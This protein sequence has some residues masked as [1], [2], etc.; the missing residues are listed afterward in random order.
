[1]TQLKMRG[2]ALNKYWTDEAECKDMPKNDFFPL[3]GEKQNQSAIDACARCTVREE[4]ANWA[5]L[6]EVHGYWGGLTAKE[7]AKIRV[8]MSIYPDIPESRYGR[9]SLIVKRRPRPPC[10]TQAG[11]KSHRLYNEIVIPLRDGG[12]GCME[13][14]TEKEKRYQK[15]LLAK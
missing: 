5:V 9:S 8:Q 7:R 4:C 14:N 1:L 15:N 13:A 6:H 11:Y 10:G 12:C 2:I 3:K